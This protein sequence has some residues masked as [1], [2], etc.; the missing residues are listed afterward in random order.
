MHYLFLMQW[1][2]YAMFCFAFFWPHSAACGIL[3]PDQGLNPGSP[4]V[5]AQNL[6]HCTS[7]KYNAFAIL[8]NKDT[9][10]IQRFCCTTLSMG[11]K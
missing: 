5:Q 7:G 6:N 8:N 9:L 1:D 4:A 10:R 3:V 11:K 2:G